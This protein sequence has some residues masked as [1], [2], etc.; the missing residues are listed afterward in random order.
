MLT[1]SPISAFDDNYI[2]MFHS[3]DSRDVFVVDPG[4][5]APVEEALKHYKLSLAGI[6]ITHQTLHDT[7]LYIGHLQS[8]FVSQPNVGLH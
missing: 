7:P 5:P 2:W 8:D 4:D 6:L 1:I 3:P